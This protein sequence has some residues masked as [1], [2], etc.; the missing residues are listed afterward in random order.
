MGDARPLY[1]TDE[2]ARALERVARLEVRDKDR[3]QELRRTQAELRV[4]T[5]AADR[6]KELRIEA[7]REKDKMHALLI[8]ERVRKIPGRHL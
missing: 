5:R 2:M 3:S 7:E 8:Q 1:K 6:E 4:A